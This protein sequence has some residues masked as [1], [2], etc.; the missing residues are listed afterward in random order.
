MKEK[1][2]MAVLLLCSYP[3]WLAI[4]RGNMSLLVLVLLMYAMSLKDSEKNG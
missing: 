2:W 1:K 3:F 4:E